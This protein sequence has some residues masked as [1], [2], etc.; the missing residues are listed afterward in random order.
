MRALILELHPTL[1]HTQGLVA[2]VRD[3]GAAIA[4]REGLHVRVE[5]DDRRLEIDTDTELDA[6]RVIQEALHNAVKH[7]EAKSVTVRIQADRAHDGTLVLEVTDDGRGFDPSSVSGRLGLVSM[8]E[9]AERM[10]GELTIR[11][12]PGAGTTVRAAVPGVVGRR[13]E[14]ET[15]VAPG[16]AP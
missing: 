6:Y 9:R 7:A 5:A 3:Q 8:R 4:S 16:L 12:R 10:G 13:R 2:V 1:L 11:S 14:D 15:P